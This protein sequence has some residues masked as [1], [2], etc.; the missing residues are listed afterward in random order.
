M[1]I[2][3]G[4][5]WGGNRIRNALLL[6]A[7]IELLVAGGLLIGALIAGEGAGGL[8]L[9]AAVLGAVGLGLLGWA[10]NVGRAQ[11]RIRSIIATGVSGTARI[12]GVTQTGV[13]VNEQPQVELQLEVHLPGRDPYLVRQ[14]EIV[15]ISMM[16][17]VGIGAELPVRVDRGD[18]S[19]VV[20]LWGADQAAEAALADVTPDTLRT[21]LKERRE[22]V[23]ANGIPATALFRKARDS[24]RSIGEY[25][26]IEMEVQ[27]EVEDGRPPFIDSGYAAVPEH[28]VDRVR[29]GVRIPAQVR[30]DDPDE[31]AVDWDAA[32][33]P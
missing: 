9:T 10:R 17:A 15:P 26:M 16:S 22:R 7:W 30:R 5:S 6:T 33:T 28:V 27:I 20:V 12:E 1:S 19:K 29:P 23:R 25:R 32:P 14:K 2:G 18:L 3:T 11:A 13:T 8:L 31:Y 24:G 21:M 4:P